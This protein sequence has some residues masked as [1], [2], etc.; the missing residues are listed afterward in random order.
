MTEHVTICEVGPR[1]GLQI[2]KTRMSTDDKIAWIADTLPVT[3]TAPEN[4]LWK[5]FVFRRELPGETQIIT[6]LVQL[7]PSKI[8]WR[9]PEGQKTIIN[10]PLT[11]TPPAGAGNTS[12]ATS[13]ARIS[14]GFRF[15]GSFQRNSASCP[16]RLKILSS[17][18]RVSRPVLVFCKEG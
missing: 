10:L 3:V 15:I 14:S 13:R 5:D 2:A 18:G 1:D 12:S 11:I 4:V 17:M 9:Q 7:P 6:H 16:A 8:V